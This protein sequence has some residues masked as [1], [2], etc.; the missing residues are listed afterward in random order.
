MPQARLGRKAKKV[1]LDPL[2]LLAL[3]GLMEPLA[4]RE[5]PALRERLALT[6]PP[7]LPVLPVLLVRTV[8]VELSV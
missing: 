2:A 3:L 5:L 8:V 4:L 1:Q 6:D 7:V